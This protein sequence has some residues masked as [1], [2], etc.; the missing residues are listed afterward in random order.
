MDLII[1]WVGAKPTLLE[2]YNDSFGGSEAVSHLKLKYGQTQI[3]VKL[4]WLSKLNNTLQ[5]I[6]SKGAVEA[7]VYDQ[8]R[9]VL[10]KGGKSQG[11]NVASPIKD[12][13]DCANVLIANFVAAI[14]KKESLLISAADVSTSIEL[15]DECYLNAKRFNLPWYASWVKGN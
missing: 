2:S 7:G 9:Y 4:S 11:V 10:K 3:D 13:Y 8:K 14:E 15:I 5:I 1:W 12:Y 6:G